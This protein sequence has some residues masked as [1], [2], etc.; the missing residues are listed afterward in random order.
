MHGLNLLL[1][2]AYG[3]TLQSL[4]V[5]YVS[6]NPAVATLQ[7][8]P[9]LLGLAPGGALLWGSR[10]LV[11]RDVTSFAVRPYGSGGPALLYTTRRK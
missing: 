10:V 6:S 1:L 5:I 7:D 11:P 8:T 9:P 3:V 4:R 2:V